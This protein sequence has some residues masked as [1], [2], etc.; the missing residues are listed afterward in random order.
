MKNLSLIPVAG[1]RAHTMPT[2][3]CFG[4][5]V[6][7]FP[8][9]PAHAGIRILRSDRLRLAKLAIGGDGSGSEPV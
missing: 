4:G 6:I 5:A 7:A 3:D 1:Q 2:S 9:S 8:G